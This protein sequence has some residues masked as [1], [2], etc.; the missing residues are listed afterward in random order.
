M[1]G[2]FV[3]LVA[4]GLA[5]LAGCSVARAQVAIPGNAGGP[6]L[7]PPAPPPVL[8]AQA[9]PAASR[10]GILTV[11]LPS[12]GALRMTASSL[13]DGPAPQSSDFAQPP[14]CPSDTAKAPF[15]PF[16]LGDFV[17]FVTNQFSDVKIAEG[18]SPRPM[19]RV[20]YKFNW[21]NNVDPTHFA[22]PTQTIHNVDLYREV[23]GFEKTF[24]DGQISLGVR[25]PFNTLEADAKSGAV[26]ESGIDSTQ[27]G[28]I[29]AIFKGILWE[30]RQTGDL[31]SAGA[32]LSV[33]TASSR[34]LNPGQSTLAYVQP[35]GAF[36]VNRGDFFVQGF[37]SVTAPVAHAESIVFFADTG[38][39]YWMYRDSRGGL[40]TAFAPT[41]EL[42][43]ADP[44]RQ[45]EPTVAD[46]GIFD[47]LKVHNVVDCTV[48]GT[49]EFAN[50]ATLGFGIVVPFTGPRPFDVEA[51][52]QLNYR[53]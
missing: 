32:T 19:D 16:M 33:P 41:I 35:F 18:E 3:S 10:G 53:F 20:F 29:S 23:F 28:N 45:A 26:G 38:V 17:G 44:L 8:P 6:I 4:V 25:V 52:A 7:N 14:A 40:L 15:T 24:F 21:Y 27:F 46:F 37:V 2:R 13:G 12:L 49:F 51:L 5:V 50:S 36:I 31:L 1:H 34:L 39:G 11:T 22:N 9:E 30:N 42:H 43:F 48:G 47:G